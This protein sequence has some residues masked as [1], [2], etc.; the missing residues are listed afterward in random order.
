MGGDE[1]GV[2]AGQSWHPS[3]SSCCGLEMQD[4]SGMPHAGNAAWQEQDLGI[5]QPFMRVR[6]LQLPCVA[7][8]PQQAC[9]GGWG[10]AASPQEPAK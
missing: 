9:Q 2:V 4:E 1:Q 3:S 7:L 5:P 10:E 6:P 8:L